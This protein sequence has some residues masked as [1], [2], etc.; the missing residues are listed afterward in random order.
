MSTAT[1][2]TCTV[3]AT[4]GVKRDAPHHVNHASFVGGA[5]DLCNACY[6]RHLDATRTSTEA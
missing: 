6:A 5:A 3:H 2:T 4:L 1:Q